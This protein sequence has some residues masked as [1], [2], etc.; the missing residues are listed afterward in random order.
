MTESR[1]VV[2]TGAST[3]IGYATAADLAG[4]GWQVFA[5][6]RKQEDATRLAEA[7]GERI[8]P[9]IL[10]V[11][12]AGTLRDG[13]RE[14]AQR[15]EG[16]PLSG[17]VNNAGIAVAGP[18]LHLAEEEMTRQLDVNVTGPLR[19]VQAFAPLLGA[20]RDHDGP[21]GRIVNISSVAG[22][23]AAPLMAPYSCSKHALEAFTESLRREMLMYGIE[24][25]AINPGPIATPIWDK[26]EQLDRER[27]AGTDYVEAIDRI[28]KYML[29]RGRDG[30][31]P[32]RVA[33]AIH[34]ALTDAKP[35]LNTVITP[36]PFTQWLTGHLPRRKVDRMIAKGLG[37]TPQVLKR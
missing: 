15:L 3:G 24:V 2:I 1:S 11:T 14:V 37:L 13:A 20:K 9:L 35:K 4:R 10:D 23:S 19:A 31:P 17:L 33:R 25:V 12:D 16:R 6:V 26:A 8:V 29:K 30:L 32:E 18:I 5:G 34:K 7:L 27:Y 21:A 28:L 36:E 22:F